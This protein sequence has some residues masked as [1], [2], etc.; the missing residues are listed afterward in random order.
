M[1]SKPTDCQTFFLDRETDLATNKQMDGL[2]KK[3]AEGLSIPECVKLLSKENDAV[4][5]TINL[6]NKKACLTHHFYKFGG[7]RIQPEALC[8]QL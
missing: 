4:F 1:L 7:T 6:I 5:L 8:T 3:I 2:E